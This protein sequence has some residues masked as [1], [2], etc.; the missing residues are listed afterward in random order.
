MGKGDKENTFF[1]TWCDKCGN[2][3]CRC[4]EIAKM[5]KTRK[6]FKGSSKLKKLMQEVQNQDMKDKEAT[7]E[8]KM[9]LITDCMECPH[10]GVCSAWNKLKPSQKFTLKT[11]I[12][13]GKFILK[14][15]PLDDAPIASKPRESEPHNCPTYGGNGTVHAT[16]YSHIGQGATTNIA[17]VPC[18]SCNGAKIIWRDLHPKS[19]ELSKDEVLCIRSFI[20]SRQLSAEFDKWVEEWN[21]PPPKT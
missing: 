5:E 2:I 1:G 15:C 4:E 18:Q 21:N 19:E 10:V 11:G 7:V 17:P 16:F 8:R 14:D 12:G 6:L 9:I 20:R 13:I 3:M